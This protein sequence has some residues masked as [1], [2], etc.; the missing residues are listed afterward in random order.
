MRDPKDGLP[1]VLNGDMGPLLGW[2]IVYRTEQ[3]MS[4]VCGVLESSLCPIRS[5]VSHAEVV[6]DDDG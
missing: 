4:T 2:N 6:R 5:L 1:V 3:R